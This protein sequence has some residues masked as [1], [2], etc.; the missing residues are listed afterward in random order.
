MKRS[1][2]L[3]L[4]SS[5]NNRTSDGFWTEGLKILFSAL[6]LIHEIKNA[7]FIISQGNTK[8]IAKNYW[9]NQ[10]SKLRISKNFVILTGVPV[11]PFLV[12]LNIFDISKLD[13]L[14]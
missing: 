5:H 8:F 11:Y 10:H 1:L 14:C 2:L 9:R 13:S 12:L 6:Q 4:S 7:I 3:N